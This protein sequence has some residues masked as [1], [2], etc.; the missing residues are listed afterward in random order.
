M[1]SLL[2]QPSDLNASVGSILS[3]RLSG[4]AHAVSPTTSIKPSAARSSS[5]SRIDPRPNSA[6]SPLPT[7]MPAGQLPAEVAD[8]TDDLV[9]ILAANAAVLAAHDADALTDRV[10]L[11]EHIACKRFVHDQH[12][13]GS[14]SSGPKSRPAITEVPKAAKKP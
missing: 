11:A 1:R 13:A 12:T 6:A 5:T 4:T 3:A 8:H 14:K 7:S 9:P 10:A 2:H